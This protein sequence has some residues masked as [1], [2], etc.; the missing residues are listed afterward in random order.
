MKAF[1]RG[2]LGK[3]P[4][5]DLERPW[6]QAFS[7]VTSRLD[8]YYFFRHIL[9]RLPQEAEWA[10]HCGFIGKGLNDVVATYL[11][12][13][14]FKKRELLGF[15]P[16]GIQRVDLDRYAIYVADNDHAVGSHILAQRDYEPQVSAAFRAF[17]QPGMAVVDI[18]ANIGW[19]SMLSASLVGERGRVFAFEPSPINSRFLWASKQ[20]NGFEQ[21]TLIHAA[22]SERIESLVYSSS[23]SNGFVTQPQDADPLM[24]FDADLVAA[25]PVDL[26]VP[27]DLP[28]HLIKVDVE[29]WEMKA[30][31]GA[32]GV[33][34][35]WKPRIVVEF[36][37]PAL[38]AC[39]GVSG[40]AFLEHFRALGYHFQVIGNSATLGPAEVMAA[41]GA[42]QT[43][44]IDILLVA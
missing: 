15:A 6:T 44:H 10:G 17:L 16:R 13:P 35:R 9:G 40:E 39:S 21:I 14:E 36:S 26:V 34:E 8:I 33:I 19:Y 20:A 42:A 27:P 30:L 29:G 3:H 25:L 41:Y 18:G 1:L 4:D 5:I 38:E 12:S 22:A 2:L 31:R 43:N 28:I 32:M 11:N 24:I 7:P 37:P 23:F